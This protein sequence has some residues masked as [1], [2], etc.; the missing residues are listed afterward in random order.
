MIMV[1]TAYRMCDH[2]EERKKQYRAW[3]EN[4]KKTDPKR[5][6]EI[7]KRMIANRIHRK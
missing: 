3:M 7:R 5:Y 1:A 6:L 2:V 4:L